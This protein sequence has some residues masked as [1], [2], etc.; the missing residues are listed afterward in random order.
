M[1]LEDMGKVVSLTES[2]D[3][4]ES[5]LVL[6]ILG[7]SKLELVV[8]VVVVTVLGKKRP[9]DFDSRTRSVFLLVHICFLLLSLDVSSYQTKKKVF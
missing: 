7:T 8:V 3:Y 5:L 4:P 6:E 2:I 1:N 9:E